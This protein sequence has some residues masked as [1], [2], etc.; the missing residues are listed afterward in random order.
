[1]LELLEP[2]KGH[3]HRVARL[4][5]LSGLSPPRHGPRMSVRDYRRF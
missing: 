5:E 4:V 1:M 3:R 2:Y